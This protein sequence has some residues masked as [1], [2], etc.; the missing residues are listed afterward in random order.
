MS[1]EV[2]AYVE[3]RCLECGNQF[4][5]LVGS[6]VRATCSEKCRRIRQGKKIEQWHQS[7]RAIAAAEGEK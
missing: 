3:T 2:A 5:L 1:K 4:R 6:I 7:K